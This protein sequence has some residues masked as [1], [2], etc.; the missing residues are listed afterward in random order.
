V[1]RAPRSLAAS[2]Q[3]FLPKELDRLL[4]TAGK[5]RGKYYLPALICLGSEHEVSKQEAISLK[6]SDIDFEYKGRGIV[7]FFRIKNEKERIE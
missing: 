3:F 2:N 4:E 1:A 7:R 5:V 6:W